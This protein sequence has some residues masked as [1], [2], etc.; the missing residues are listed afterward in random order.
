VEDN[1]TE[2]EEDVMLWVEDFEVD[3]RSDGVKNDKDDSTNAVA[4]D[5]EDDMLRVRVVDDEII[6]TPTEEIVIAVEEFEMLWIKKLDVEVVLSRIEE[7]EPEVLETLGDEM[8]D[9]EDEGTAV[10]LV[11]NRVEEL[12]KE[13]FPGK[14]VELFSI[15]VTFRR[16][17]LLHVEQY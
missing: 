13:I 11:E 14:V 15:D 2:D 7:N 8:T 16:K 3:V 12:I 17:P 9:A 4:E 1:V 10:D 5:E 6:G